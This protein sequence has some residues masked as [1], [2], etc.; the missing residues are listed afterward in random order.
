MGWCKRLW[1]DWAQTLCLELPTCPPN[2]GSW[3]EIAG[4]SSKSCEFAENSSKCCEIPVK[5]MG[6]PE[7]ACRSTWP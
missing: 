5:S 7:P 4:N 2:S 3:L 6:I 1:P